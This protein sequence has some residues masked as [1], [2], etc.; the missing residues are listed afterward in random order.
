MKLLESRASR[1]AIMLACLLAWFGASNHCALAALEGLVRPSAGAAQ[2]CSHCPSGGKDKSAPIAMSACCKGLKVTLQT[3]KRVQFSN[4]LGELLIF[5]VGLVSEPSHKPMAVLGNLA[6]S[7]P[8]HSFAE[9]VLHRSLLAHA[10]PVL[11]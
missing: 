5:A 4:S 2:S 8:G 1:I 6:G 9:S 3:P 7:P 11:A 10:P